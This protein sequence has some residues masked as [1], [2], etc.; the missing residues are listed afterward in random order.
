MVN[1][2]TPITLT[3]RELL[4]YTRGIVTDVETHPTV[5]EQVTTE[6]AKVVEN[7]DVIFSRGYNRGIDEAAERV[8]DGL[9]DLRS[10]YEEQG[11]TGVVRTVRQQAQAAHR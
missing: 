10:L 5:P 4:Q 2:D 3:I 1:L 6:H 7:G 9:D 11:Y 8:I